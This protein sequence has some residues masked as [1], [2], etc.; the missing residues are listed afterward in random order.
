MSSGMASHHHDRSRSH[1]RSP[2]RRHSRSRSRSP[3]RHHHS[4]WDEP[5]PAAAAPYA[6]TSAPAAYAPAPAAPYGSYGA[7]SY[8]SGGYGSPQGFGSGGNRGFSGSRGARDDLDRM[9]V[10]GRCRGG[11]FTY[12]DTQPQGQK[13]MLCMLAHAACAHATASNPPGP[14]HPAAGPPRLQQ[15]ATF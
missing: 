11:G 4:R 8:G 2:V 5:A 6:R 12:P 15:P 14:I 7:G 13:R 10:S 1:S 9:Q 3:P